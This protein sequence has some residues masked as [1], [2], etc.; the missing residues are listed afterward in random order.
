MGYI[1]VLNYN[2]LIATLFNTIAMNESMSL[3]IG[4]LRT[5]QNYG[6]TA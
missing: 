6:I 3:R 5:N 2:I 4:F 1:K